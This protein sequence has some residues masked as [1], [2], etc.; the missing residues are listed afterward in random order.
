[1]EMQLLDEHSEE[2]DFAEAMIHQV[3][4]TIE[5]CLNC[6]SHTASYLRL[7]GKSPQCGPAHTNPSVITCTFT[8]I[9]CSMEHDSAKCLLGNRCERG[10]FD[11]VLVCNVVC[12]HG[13]YFSVY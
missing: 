6:V 5:F 12:K 2:F 9:G 4:H 10:A 1:M 11:G 3:I 8:V 13:G 7:W